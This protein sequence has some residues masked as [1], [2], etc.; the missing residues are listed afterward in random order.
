[1]NNK[2]LFALIPILYFSALSA[3][4]PAPADRC[5]HSP[6]IEQQIEKTCARLLRKDPK[7]AEMF[8]Q[9]FPNTLDTTVKL[10]GEDDTFVITGDIPA[11]WLRDSSAQV[12]PYLRFAAKDENLAQLIR[13][14]LRRQFRSILIDP[15]AN[16]KD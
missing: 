3:Q 6:A 5:F 9:C 4:R 16:G 10:W 8:R 13:G 14:L 1:M 12:W 7:L 2:F 11:L 15:Y